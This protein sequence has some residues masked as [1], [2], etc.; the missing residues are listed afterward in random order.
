MH[1]F[2][3]ISQ[4]PQ[5]FIFEKSANKTNLGGIF[6]F[7][8]ILIV[9]VISLLYLFDYISNDKYNVEY[10]S[11][12]D[13]LTKDEMDKLNEDD[14]FNPKILFKFQLYDYYKKKKLS[15]NFEIINLNDASYSLR[16]EIFLKA[17]D[18]KINIGIFYYCENGTE[19]CDL[20]EEEKTDFNFYLQITY[21]GF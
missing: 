13:E 8:Y 10:S 19:N 21:R 14:I 12:F 20:K 4:S 15:N 16:D 17:R 18:S 11:F 3:F 9:I 1:S 6:S 5:V 2:D 7:I